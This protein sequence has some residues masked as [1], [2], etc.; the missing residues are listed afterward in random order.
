MP[1][2]LLIGHDGQ[3]GFELQRTLAALGPVRAVCYP[4]INFGDPDSI[5]RTVRETRPELIL[6]AAAYTAVDKAES[7]V[8]LCRRVNVDAPRILAE[9]AVRLGAGLVHYS[10]DFVFAG[11]LRR[12]YTETD[13]ARPISV[14]GRTKLE[15]DQA[16]A[17]SGVPHLIFRIAWVYGL[18]GRNFLLTIRRLA[19]E[20][21]SLRIVDDQ[22]GSPTWCRPVA[23]MTAAALAARPSAAALREVSGVYHAVCGGETSWCEF[24][25]AF[26]PTEVRVQP[27]ATADY[28]TPAHRP[29]YSALDCGK[30]RR[31]FGLALPPWQD[32]LRVCLAEEQTPRV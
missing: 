1:R 2:I 3:I 16:I 25:R 32:A 10:T 4:D 18:R 14:Y 30:L 31:V 15:G 28:P 9:E 13:D 17:A 24:A 20:G 7:E 5:V 6:N 21:K 19:A 23:E 12:P 22:I 8:D 26:L 11:T 29:A 27:I